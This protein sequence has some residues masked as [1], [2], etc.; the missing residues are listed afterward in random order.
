MATLSMNALKEKDGTNNFK[1][2]STQMINIF[3]SKKINY[4][5][6]GDSPSVRNVMHSKPN[7]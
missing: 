1:T 5:F 3:K 4:L 6:D 7:N 2:W